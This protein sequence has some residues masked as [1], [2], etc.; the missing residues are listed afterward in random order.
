MKAIKSAVFG[1]I[2]RFVN[3]TDFRIVR[4]ES[5]NLLHKV[6]LIQLAQRWAGSD[7][8]NDLQEF[9]L[10]NFHRSRAQLQQDLWALNQ[11]VKSHNQNGEG[12]YFVEFGATDGITLSNTFLLEKTFG[13]TGILCEPATSFHSELT[14]NRTSKIDRRCVFSKSGD[15]IQFHEVQNKE[16]SGIKEYQHIG[17]WEAERRNHISYTVETVTLN[18]LL[19]TN[20][21]PSVINYMSIDTEGSEYEILK[22]F[23]FHKWD[24][25]CLT[26]EHNYSENESKIDQLLERNG[27]KR[28]CSSAS[29]WDGWYI[30]RPISE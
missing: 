3:T 28:V 16:L 6:G 13:W 5:Y 8:P 22:D 27:Y 24:I 14:S 26:I 2:R 10:W 1:L 4:L 15:L 9:V 12:G 18:D 23:P 19:V 25:E 29:V 20:H 21:S 17:G 11:F 30:K 7:I